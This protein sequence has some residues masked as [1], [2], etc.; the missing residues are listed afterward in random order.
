MRRLVTQRPHAFCCTAHASV[1]IVWLLALFLYGPYGAVGFG[2][3]IDAEDRECFVESL[4]AGGSLA[5]TF[6]VTDGGSFDIDAVMY[7]TTVAPLNSVEETTRLHYSEALIKMRENTTTVIVNEWRRANEG[8]QSYTAPSAAETKHGLP[9]EITVCFDNSFS[10]LSPKWLL[11]QF[12]KRDV[13]EVDPESTT[14]AEAEIETKLHKHGTVLFELATAAERM[15]QMGESNRVRYESL[16][17]IVMVGLVGNIVIL[18]LM[19]VYQYMTLTR[20]LIRR[21]A[22]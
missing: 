2:T 6:R 11:F 19:A 5:F 16:A 9:A 20:F 4:A 18:A 17:S 7:A 12:L 22:K 3:K 10:R 15:R 13:P 14:R 8:S 1:V 21:R